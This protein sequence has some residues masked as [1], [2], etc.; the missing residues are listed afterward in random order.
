M[1]IGTGSGYVLC[2]LILI[3]KSLGIRSP[4]F[5]ATDINPMASVSTADTLSSHG[6]RDKVDIVLADLACSMYSTGSID[7]LLFNPPYVPTPEEEVD[8]MGSIAAAWAGGYRG[9]KVLNRLLPQLPQLM[10]PE[11]EVF[12]VAVQENEP[13]DIIRDMQTLGFRGRV[14]MTRTADEERL[15]ILYFQ[16][17]LV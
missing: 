13:E 5:L 15:H 9:R 6:L 2:S 7:L 3:L 1:E 4:A 11:G 12:I 17:G 14:A 8:D 10:S 16:K